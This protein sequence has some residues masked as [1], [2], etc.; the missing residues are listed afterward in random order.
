[1]HE[2]AIIYSLVNFFS[3]MTMIKY[4]RRV[5]GVRGYIT[6]LEKSMLSLV[7]FAVILILFMV[8][9]ATSIW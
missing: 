5:P 4:L 2:I 3:W 9:F 7:G 8:A 1:M 6:L